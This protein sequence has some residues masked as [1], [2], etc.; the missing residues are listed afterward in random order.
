MKTSDF[1]EEVGDVLA[2]LRK[3]FDYS[4]RP[5]EDNPDPF[6]ND[7]DVMQH[8]R[9]EKLREHVANKTYPK[10][11]DTKTSEQPRQPIQSQSPK[12]HRVR[13]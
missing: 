2:P 9:D 13:G 3:K 12:Q 5:T 6:S 1:Y 11:S 7:P 4:V 10:E 8:A